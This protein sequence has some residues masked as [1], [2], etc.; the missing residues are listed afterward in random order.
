MQT[1][2]SA[3]SD[4]SAWEQIAPLLDDAMAALGEKDRNAVMLRF[5][6][7][8]S[9]EEVGLALGIDTAT[10]QK[11]VWRAVDKLRQY[12]ARHG[13]AFSA[14]TIATTLSAHALHAVPSGLA[15]TVAATAAL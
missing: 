7:Q 3:S 14:A 11:R 12:F 5:F 4:E 6:E 8:K 15:A 2:S 13:A 9:L 1:I 10:A